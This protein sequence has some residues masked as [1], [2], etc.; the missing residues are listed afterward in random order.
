MRKHYAAPAIPPLARQVEIAEW[1]ARAQHSQP[2]TLRLRSGQVCDLQWRR[3]L[4]FFDCLIK[5][6][7]LLER[8]HAELLVEHA[9]TFTVLV[10]CRRALAR[11]DEEPHQLAVC[12]FMQRVERQPAA[13]VSDCGRKRAEQR[14]ALDQALQS[15]GKVAAQA[16]GLEALPIVKGRAIAQAE[17]SHEVIAIERS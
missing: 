2:G 9:H 17:A 4:V 3:R 13:S 1:M 14:M 11:P 7:G 10:D 6:G 5:L 8:R 12:W 15:S 16:F